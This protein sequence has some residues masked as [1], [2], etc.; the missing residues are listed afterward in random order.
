MR[1]KW[2]EVYGNRWV[3]LWLILCRFWFVTCK[4]LWRSYL[5]HIITEIKL[6][7]ALKVNQHSA[8][9]H[10][11]MDTVIVSK[12]DHIKCTCTVK[13]SII[14]VEINNFFLHALL[15]ILILVWQ[16][17]LSLCTLSLFYSLLY[18]CCLQHL[19]C[20]KQRCKQQHLYCCYLL[21]SFSP[22]PS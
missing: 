16:L 22:P 13:V 14:P 19:T 11:Q 6:E 12:N 18:C 10:Q 20:W 3:T 8:W 5:P 2:N 15:F 17:F 21:T 9:Y 4:C 1:M 7:S